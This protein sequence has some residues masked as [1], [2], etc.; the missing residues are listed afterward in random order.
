M[1]ALLAALAGGLIAAGLV[2]LVLWLWPAEP[3]VARPRR[4][5]GLLVRWRRI[6]TRTRWL[7]VCGLGLGAL[8]ALFTGWWIAVLVLPV[9]AVGLPVL[10]IG[11]PEKSRIERME[12]MAEWTRGLAGVL[13]AGVGLEQALVAMLKSTPPAISKEVRTL[14]GRM[15]SRWTSEDALRTFADDLDDPTGDLI[16][17]YLILGARRRGGSLAAVLQTLADSVA[18]DVAARRQVEAERAKPRG[19]MRWTT[20]ITA[21]G[22]T[23]FSLSGAMAGYSSPVGQIALACLLGLYALTLLWMQRMANPRPLPRV[24]GATVRQD[25]P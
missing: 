2:M 10:I 1:T 11:T 18:E 21:V 20:I 24:I 4:S 19:A 5:P 3:D 14:V 16:A 15:Q 22:L 13:S 8:V 9:A 17:A 6:P 25:R 12:A 7:S 23:A